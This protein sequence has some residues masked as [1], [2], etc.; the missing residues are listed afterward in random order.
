[1]DHYYGYKSMQKLTYEQTNTPE[2]W[3]YT[4]QGPDDGTYTISFVNDFTEPFSFYNTS[5]IRA[6]AAA[7]DVETAINGFYDFM[8]GTTVSVTRAMFNADGATTSNIN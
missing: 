2:E 5:S 4:I 6:D 3:S 1:M 8:Y 7:S